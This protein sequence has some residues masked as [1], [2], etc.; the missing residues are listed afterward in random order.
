MVFPVTYGT[1][2]AFYE[3]EKDDNGSIQRLFRTKSSRFTAMI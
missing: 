3:R 1:W 2:T